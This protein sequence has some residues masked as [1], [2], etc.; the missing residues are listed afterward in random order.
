MAFAGLVATGFGCSLRGAVFATRVVV[1]VILVLLGRGIVATDRYS[2]DIRCRVVRNQASVV[3]R[4]I[5]DRVWARGG[6]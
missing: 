1:D 6:D 5:G 2:N 4:G 3:V